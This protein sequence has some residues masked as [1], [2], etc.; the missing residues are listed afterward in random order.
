MR[1]LC[2][3]AKDERWVD[4]WSNAETD[5]WAENQDVTMELEEREYNGKT[6]FSGSPVGG[7]KPSVRIEPVFQEIL[8][9]LKQFESY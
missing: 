6:Y 3:G 7:K 4:V 5:T 1:F 2:K 9:E 8:A